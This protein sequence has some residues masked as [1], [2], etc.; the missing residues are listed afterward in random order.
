M[1]WQRA[2][3]TFPSALQVGLFRLF[4]GSAFEK[5]RRCGATNRI[6]ARARDHAANHIAPPWE[7]FQHRARSFP[8]EH[9]YTDVR[10]QCSDELSRSPQASFS[11]ADVHDSRDHQNLERRED[12]HVC[13]WNRLRTDRSADRSG[14]FY[15]H[16]GNM[17][18][19]VAIARNSDHLDFRLVR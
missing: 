19:R 18:L 11:A 17:K 7:E 10:S 5:V 4:E 2:T 14:R 1:R 13:Q 9:T 15:Q 12:R 3:R 16:L 6:R 8:K